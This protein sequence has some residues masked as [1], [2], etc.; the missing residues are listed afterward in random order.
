MVGIIS[1]CRSLLY[2]RGSSG[3]ILFGYFRAWLYV[4]SYASHQQCFHLGALGQRLWPAGHA[5]QCV[6]RLHAANL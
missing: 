6:C 1:Q 5:E 4:A 3:Y 2:R